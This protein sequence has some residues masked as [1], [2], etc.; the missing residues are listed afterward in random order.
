MR[1]FAVAQTWLV[2]V[3]GLAG[4]PA[5]RAT[6]EQHAGHLVAAARTRLGVD[7]QHIV[8]LGEGTTP[9][10]G[11]EQIR[12]TLADVASR[13]EPNALVVVALM[14]HGSALGGE[15]R[16][17]LSGPDLTAAAF[18]RALEPLRTQE[19][20]VVVATSA[21]GPWTAAL[22]GPRRAVITATRSAIERDETVFARYLVEAV[23][24]EGG[25]ADRNG[26][27]SVRELFEYA[28]Q[29]VDRH[30]RELRRLRTEHAL[31]DDNGDGR[32]S[33]AASDS[34]DGSRAA[35][36]Y[37]NGAP[38][39]AGADAAL[40]PLFARRDSLERAVAALRARRAA[41]DSAAYERELERLLLDLA[42]VGRTIRERRGTGGTNP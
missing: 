16:F 19:V 33:L 17:N 14:G 42:Q 40:A 5:R 24:G 6:L 10:A 20:V 13:A 28:R 34:G 11:A 26:R 4:D 18:A 37:L 12:R 32:G 35:T 39:A 3:T 27:L 30:Y 22:A 7:P 31:L 9:A 41:L 8:Q 21:S 25:D 2:V 38:D 23:A 15:P 1:L 36:L 29:G